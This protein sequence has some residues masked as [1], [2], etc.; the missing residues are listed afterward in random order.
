MTKKNTTT[1]NQLDKILE[2][3]GKKLSLREISAIVKL[4]HEKIRKIIKDYQ[5]K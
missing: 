5:K 1:I 3:H 2:L 4:S